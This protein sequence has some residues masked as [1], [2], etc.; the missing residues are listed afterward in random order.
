MIKETVVFVEHE[1]LH[2]L[3]HYLPAQAPLKDFIHHNTL[4]A[5]QDLPFYDALLN[6]STIF[7]Y[8][9]SL[10]IAEY[11]ALFN[12]GKIE[13]KVLDKVISDS[14]GRENLEGWKRKLLQSEYESSLDKRVGEL[15]SV[16]KSHYKIDLDSLVH[17]NL[18]RILNSYLDQGISIW[19]FPVW[20]KGFLESLREMERLAMTS[21]FQTKRAKQLLFSNDC[22]IEK[23]LSIVVGV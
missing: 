6:A 18:F 20:N 3:K 1:I 4:H 14:Y 15:R 9:T 19:H 12:E 8:K 11:R 22:S 2:R 21:F 23:L 5:F 17:P 16:W 13:E 10:S 7:G